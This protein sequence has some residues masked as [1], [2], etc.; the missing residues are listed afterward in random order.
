MCEVSTVCEVSNIC[1]TTSEISNTESTTEMLNNVAHQLPQRNI[2]QGN[3][4]I[5]KMIL[6]ELVNLLSGA[7][8]QFFNMC[9]YGRLVHTSNHF[10]CL[11]TLN[12]E[13]LHGTGVAL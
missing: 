5:P 11:I 7:L 12:G 1:D 6:T 8:L 4:V 13:N 10:P 9:I 2:Y 3:P